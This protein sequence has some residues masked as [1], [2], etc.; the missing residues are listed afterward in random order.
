MSGTTAPPDDAAIRR[1]I[2]QLGRVASR[3]EAANRS[4]LPGWAASGLSGLTLGFGDEL[5]AAA[6]STFGSTPYNQALEEER[7]NLDRFRERNPLTAAG[8]EMIGAIPT[9]LVPL[10]W[11][12]R[13]AR[14]P[15]AG[16]AAAGA[17]AGGA[18]LRS[19]A[20]LGA[21]TGGA[22]GAVQGF[23]EGE[24]GLGPRLASAAGGGAL[25][26]GVGA[27]AGPVLQG[28]GQAAPAVAERFR[29]MTG[30]GAEDLAQRNVA[31]LMS[32]DE[33]AGG[34]V[35]AARTRANEAA[36][37]LRTNPNAMPETLAEIGGPNTR[38]A[39]EGLA[40]MPGEGMARTVRTMTERQAGRLD[41]VDE[42]LRDTFG[43]LADARL[44]QAA[45]FEERS[46]EARPLYD[47]VFANA[48]A[49]SQEH[50]DL[51]RRV[52][53]GAMEEARTIARI[54]GEPFNLDYEIDAAGRVIFR[55]IP[56][57]Q[58]VAHI[59]TGLREWMEQRRAS[60]RGQRGSGATAAA[61]GL[62]RQ[63]TGALEEIAP[64]HAA[65][66]RVWA[67]H[68]GVL[69]AIDLG[70][71]IFRDPPPEL[72][73]ELAQMAPN[74]RDGFLTGAM[75]ALRDRLSTV[76][77]TAANSANPINQIFSNRQQREALNVMI[78]ALGLPQ[79]E[80]EA[81]FR[82]MAASFEREAR[83]VAT[84]AEML[85]G[86]ATA[87]RQAT[88]EMFGAAGGGA[89]GGGVLG[90]LAGVDMG[91]SALA[92]AGA[93]A[94]SRRVAGNAREAINRLSAQMLAETNP[95]EQLRLLGTIQLMQR[96]LGQEAA[97]A[98]PLSVARAGLLAGQ[99]PA[100]PE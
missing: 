95:Q 73:R 1:Y 7:A 44:A 34:G 57:A 28:I 33:L 79:R 61:E 5:T 41:R 82:R 65:A 31:R 18:G 77:D 76:R 19:A 39:L 30:I 24:G 23:G 14:V 8:T 42:I 62:Y 40:N 49:P 58:D 26:A 88:Q 64:G 90:L 87:R 52:P 51:L 36:D 78:D 17:M 20:R 2:E 53:A 12:M 11:A 46:R 93:A 35:A 81:R 89:A 60:T 85:R 92:G 68:S 91:A 32:A 47:Q 13:L 16:A 50:V 54:N 96:R 70:A 4:V 63:I 38:R 45:R 21:I 86:S 59:R 9:M 74:A 80:G 15:A 6:R 71:R 75:T 48:R 3:D 99:A 66:A 27:A 43:D 55:S 100:T 72:R 56:S 22:A 10:G 84:E 25:G 97:G 83:G 29:T 37:L 94:A 98:S 67:D 69:D